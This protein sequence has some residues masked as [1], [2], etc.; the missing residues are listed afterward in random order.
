M[1]TQNCTDLLMIN[2][3]K[4]FFLHLYAIVEPFNIL[5]CKPPS[6]HPHPPN[7]EKCLQ[8]CGRELH[9]ENMCL[10]YADYT[11]TSASQTSLTHTCEQ[12]CISVTACNPSTYH[13]C[14]HHSLLGYI[15]LLCFPVWDRF[16]EK[17]LTSNRRPLAWPGHPP[18]RDWTLSSARHAREKG[19]YPLSCPCTWCHCIASFCA[20]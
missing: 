8:S 11:S 1:L 19:A 18:P 20:Q 10:Q 5:I 2:H 4:E 17:T 16:L 14:P 13:S 15:Y 12:T 3:N 7:T 9:R 6:L